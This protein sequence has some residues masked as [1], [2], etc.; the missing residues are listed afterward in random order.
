MPPLRQNPHSTLILCLAGVILSL[1]A[2]GVESQE[3]LRHIVQVTPGILA[4]L[5]FWRRTE[6][7]KAAAHP[8]FLFW[9]VIVALIWLHLLGLSRIITGNFTPVEIGL[10]V[11][12]GL[13]CLCG[14][15]VSRRVLAANRGANGLLFAGFLGLQVLAM[16][17]SL[18]PSIAHR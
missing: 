6:R 13:F 15:V 16:W 2:V 14:L 5:L 18:Q 17:T 4:L 9:L 10:T 11:F 8:V 3:I 12:I 1:L 7:M